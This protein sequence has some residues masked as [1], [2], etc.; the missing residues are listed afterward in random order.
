MF[1]KIVNIKTLNV[2]FATGIQF[3]KYLKSL[4]ISAGF[5]RGFQNVF[6]RDG[7]QGLGM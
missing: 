7:K 3:P 2:H 6:Q 1:L 5:V 4:K